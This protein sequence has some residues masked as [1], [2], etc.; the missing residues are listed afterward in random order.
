MS[1]AR[2]WGRV[3]N[4]TVTKALGSKVWDVDGAEYIDCTSGIAVTNVGHC[5]PQ[6]VAAIQKQAEQFIHCQ[7]NVH[8]SDTLLA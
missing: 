1:L 2:C 7:V 3:T 6:V 4:L 5:H 8:Y